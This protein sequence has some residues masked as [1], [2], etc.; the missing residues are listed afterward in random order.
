[1]I[2]DNFAPERLMEKST[3][4]STGE[5]LVF[6]RHREYLASAMMGNFRN[7]SLCGWQPGEPIANFWGINDPSTFR[8]RALKEQLDLGF[9]TFDAFDAGETQFE[10]WAARL[11]GIRA[12]VWY[13]YASTIWIFCKWLTAN[14]GPAASV[15]RPKGIFVT[16][17]RLH[18]FQRELIGS[19]LNAPVFNL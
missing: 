16:A 14:T 19:T 6:Y 15:P 3:G 2:A 5:P 13:G 8:M 10:E 7:F 12:T 4:G 1:M 11:Q 9:N 18:D 17:E